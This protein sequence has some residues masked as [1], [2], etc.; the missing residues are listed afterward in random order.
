MNIAAFIFALVGAGLS[1][2]QPVISI[3]NF[4]SGYSLGGFSF[5]DI[6]TES[7]SGSDAYLGALEIIIIALIACVYGL[8]T[9]MRIT[10]RQHIFGLSACSIWLFVRI[11][12]VLSNTNSLQRSFAG[13]F[14]SY[15]KTLLIWACCYAL[16]A[17]FAY[18]DKNSMQTKEKL[19]SSFSSSTTSST[20]TSFHFET[21]KNEVS[22]PKTEKKFE[23]VIGVETQALVKRAFIFMEDKNIDEAERYFE[24]ALRQDPENSSAY[25]GK[26]MIELKVH[27]IDELSNI[28]I[29]L[30]EQKLFQ[31]AL[32]FA[33]DEEKIR[34]E[35]CLE[36]QNQQIEVKRQAENEQKYINALKMREKLNSSLD[37]QN[38]INLLTSIA[39]YKDSEIIIQEIRHK[40][41]ELEEIERKYSD[42]WMAKRETESLENLKYPNIEKFNRAADMF[43]ALGDY[44]DC[45]SIA[46]ELRHSGV[47]AVERAR[48]SRKKTIILATVLVAVIVGAG[49]FYAVQKINKSNA[50]KREEQARIEA[51]KNEEKSRIEAL[52]LELQNRK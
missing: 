14:F 30:N 8:C 7:S 6:L 2:F 12:I 18:L 13:G 9:L 16:A 36:A 51:E 1:I 44:K 33:D 10:K 23:P 46:Q 28:S 25:L 34:L 39:P 3:P 29:P 4:G 19:N 48:R 15:Q 47:E 20:T 26:L 35:Y 21:Q 40:K 41:Q 31:R 45:K 11:G 42:A 49:I 27:N 32:Q 38:L 24:Q 52:K 50:L 43:E 22:S 37:A 5:L 17:I